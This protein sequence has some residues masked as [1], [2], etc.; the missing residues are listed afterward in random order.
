MRVGVVCERARGCG[1]GVACGLGVSRGDY[2]RAVEV[3][4]KT[5][6]LSPQEFWRAFWI[7]VTEPG[8]GM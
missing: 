4:C 7:C 8:T 3:F 1:L 6:N 5:Y 2:H